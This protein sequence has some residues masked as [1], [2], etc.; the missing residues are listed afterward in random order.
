MTDIYGNLVN[1]CVVKHSWQATLF[2]YVVFLRL[3]LI[4]WFLCMTYAQLDR[5]CAHNRNQELCAKLC[6]RIIA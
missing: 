6:D 4:F 5:L 1:S 2:T 3:V